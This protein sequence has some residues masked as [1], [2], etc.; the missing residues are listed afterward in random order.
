MFDND[1]NSHHTIDESSY[2]NQIA[3]QNAM[4]ILSLGNTVNNRTTKANIRTYS[5]SNSSCESLR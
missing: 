3:M 5:P 4:Q 2:Q 1:N